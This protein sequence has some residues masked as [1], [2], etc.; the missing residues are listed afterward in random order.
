MGQW[1]G[2]IGGVCRPFLGPERGNR[3]R[4]R[5]GHRGAV[6]PDVQ[7]STVSNRLQYPAVVFGWF[8][9]AHDLDF[10]ARSRHLVVPTHRPDHGLVLVRSQARGRCLA[11]RR[12]RLGGTPPIKKKRIIK[13]EPSEKT[14]E[15]YLVKTEVKTLETATPET[16]SKAMTFSTMDEEEVKKITVPE[17]EVY[18]LDYDT[19][20]DDIIS[21]FGYNEDDEVLHKRL[22][23]IIISKFRDIRDDIESID[24]L[25]KSQKIGGLEFSKEQASELLK[26]IKK[27]QEEFKQYHISS[28][29]GVQRIEFKSKKPE[30]VK[31]EV[32][33]KTLQEKRAEEMG[34][35]QVS[36]SIEP[37]FQVVEEKITQPEIIAVPPKQIAVTKEDVPV[38]NNQVQ[39]GPV[40]D[41]EDG[42]PVLRM[43]E[44][45]MVKPVS[46]PLLSKEGQGEVMKDGK[47]VAINV[48]EPFPAS[49]LKGEE[50]ESVNNFV[51]EKTI[52]VVPV[53]ASYKKEEREPLQSENSPRST[54]RANVFAHHT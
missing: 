36:T 50:M 8:L 4:R 1:S 7:Q 40:M 9:V 15:D 30:F 12:D 32:K 24:A 18:K 23:N 10:A 16:G 34:I 25:T 22:S 29:D 21:K 11:G 39:S 42:L 19:L 49:P 52:P 53:Q 17:A 5:L 46:I 43:P 33:V 13:K 44:D 28:G 20:A 27:E 31:R 26:L 2:I 54:Q 47:Q 51:E 38:A 45:L 41:E 35:S 6:L 3:S 48:S 14:P 37:S